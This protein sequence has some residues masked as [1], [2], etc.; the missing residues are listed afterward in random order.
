M[1]GPLQILAMSLPGGAARPGPL[2]AQVDRLEGRG[3]VRVLDML[4]VSKGQDG[5]VMELPLG[6]DEDFGPLVSRLLPVL[7]GAGTPA[8]AFKSC[9]R[10][11]C[12]CRSGR[13]SSS[14]SSSSGGPETSSPY[15]S[16]RAVRCDGA[17]RG[18]F[19]ELA[20]RGQAGPAAVGRQVACTGHPASTSVDHRPCRTRRCSASKRSAF[21]S[22]TDP[23]RSLRP[24]SNWLNDAEV[25]SGK[26]ET[27]LPTTTSNVVAGSVRF[28][29]PRS[30]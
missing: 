7:S 28:Q 30:E 3:A 11:R 19:R 14:F 22:L 16:R 4:V 5:T 17:D 20:R 26:A 13:R 18:R 12:L 10:E 29:V 25:P 27:T 23:G 6:E 8:G 24:G 15:S 21:P 2:L 9:G 1:L